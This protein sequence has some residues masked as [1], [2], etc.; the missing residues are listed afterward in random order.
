MEHALVKRN[1]DL[2]PQHLP[3]PILV[4]TL[5]LIAETDDDAIRV[6]PMFRRLMNEVAKR[7]ED[8]S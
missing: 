7:L 1:I 8:H 5:R 4:A 2:E 3:S 6:D